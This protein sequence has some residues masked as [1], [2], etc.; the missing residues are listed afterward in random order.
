MLLSQVEM[1]RSQVAHATSQFSAKMEQASR[2]SE[3][4]GKVEK[5]G[6][7]W[8]TKYLRVSRDLQILEAKYKTLSVE[9]DQARTG[10]ESE[11]RELLAARRE[12]A[13]LERKREMLEQRVEDVSRR[14]AQEKEFLEKKIEEA[15]R[16][17]QTRT[18]E[19]LAAEGALRRAEAERVGVKEK[20]GFLEK[21]YEHVLKFNEEFQAK[22]EA[23]RTKED[24]HLRM[25]NELRQKMDE[26]AL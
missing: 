4:Y 1:M 3:D 13:L 24:S 11:V 17:V 9:A 6:R 19:Q 20:L 7:A 21:D 2:Q 12:L 16:L 8:K 15:H 14:G 26:L 10:R 23:Y 5:E 18:S 22:F 25:A